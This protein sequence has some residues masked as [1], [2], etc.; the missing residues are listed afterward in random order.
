MTYQPP[1]D[2]GGR[3]S[4]APALQAPTPPGRGF[5][6]LGAMN[7]AIVHRPAAASALCGFGTIRM[8]SMLETPSRGCLS[9]PN[10]WNS[11]H[12]VVGAE[13]GE[14]NAFVHF[15]IGIQPEPTGAHDHQQAGQVES[16]VRRIKELAL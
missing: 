2:R 13:T 12:T 3:P 11:A 7:A 10:L 15:V 14:G 4:S 6:S 8:R 1:P 9:A 5:L 16:S